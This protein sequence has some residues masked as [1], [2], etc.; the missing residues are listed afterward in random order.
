MGIQTN[1][2]EAM[3]VNLNGTVVELDEET[4]ELF[5]ALTSL[6][7]GVTT[8]KLNDPSMSDYEAY[9]AGGGK[10]KKAVTG[11]TSV[12]EILINPNVVKYMRAMRELGFAAS[13]M[14]RHEM[15]A[16]LSKLGKTTMDDVV[17]RH[18]GGEF[19]DVETGR[20]VDGQTFWSVKPA[21]EMQN[22]GS[23][24]IKE[25][26]AGKDG[27]KVKLHDPLVAMKQLAELGGYNKPQ[28]HRVATTVMSLDEFYGGDDE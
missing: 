14:S 19:K 16:I 8:A 22:A 21:D 12:S 27:M 24:A 17:N 2:G 13:V 26:S 23:A 20:I 1:S 4:L 5:H 6:Q 28:E 9:K 3:N 11:R 10:A 15:A 7:R 25:L 18:N